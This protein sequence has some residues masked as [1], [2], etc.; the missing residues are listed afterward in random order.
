M[1]NVTVGEICW[2]V[3]CTVTI[4]THL[5]DGSDR[6][7]VTLEQMTAVGELYEELGHVVDVHLTQWTGHWRVHQCLQGRQERLFHHFLIRTVIQTKL[8]HLK[9]PQFT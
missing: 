9:L 1:T 7:A 6:P 5:C 3:S 2:M 4:D 8:V